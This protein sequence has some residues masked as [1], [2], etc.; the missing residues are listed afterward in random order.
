MCF[1]ASPVFRESSSST[2]II[3]KGI[4][5]PSQYQKIIYSVTK[6]GTEYQSKRPV[7]VA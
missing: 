2:S 7:E 5:E 6:Y 1:K 4:S 3:L